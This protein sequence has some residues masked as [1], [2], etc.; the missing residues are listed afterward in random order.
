MTQTWKNHV[1][2]LRYH[3]DHSD[4][5]KFTQW[6]V[7]RETMFVN[8]QTY[9]FTELNELMRSP[10]W[11]T[12][13]QPAIVESPIGSPEP[14]EFYVQSSGNLIHHAYSLYRFEKATGIRIEQ[15]ES[16]LE[17][18]GGYGSFCRLVKSLGFK[19]A[20]T[21]F[22]LPE[23]CYLQSRYLGGLEIHMGG[24]VRFVTNRDHIPYSTDLY[25]GL[26]S[27][28]ELP[29]NERNQVM[30]CNA[31]AYM[32]AYQDKFEDIDNLAYF[33]EVSRVFEYDWHPESINHMPGNRY[34][35]GVFH[36]K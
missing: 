12:R 16:V 27:I 29:V 11:S 34:L 33:E 3:L 36:V 1:A 35:F 26:W 4:L 22:D 13:W 2:R 30:G 19:G 18:G 20:Y 8:Q 9:V 31:D 5:T 10:E 25:I 23:F 28:S 32:L 17:V 15:L 21:I 14:Y 7:I 6:D 24:H